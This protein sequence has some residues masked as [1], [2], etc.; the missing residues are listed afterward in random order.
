MYRG[1]TGVEDS[2][3]WTTEFYI[4]GDGNS[5]TGY[6]G[7]SLYANT[8]SST[9]VYRVLTET[10]PGELSNVKTSE[11]EHGSL[12]L[13]GMEVFSQ[14]STDLISMQLSPT[15]VTFGAK[16]S[17]PKSEDKVIVVT[18]E[19]SLTA[20][21]SGTLSWNYKSQNIPSWF[22]VS[23][24]GSQ[25]V[26]KL[27]EENASGQRT[28][29]LPVVGSYT[30]PDGRGG[31]VIQYITVVQESAAEEVKPEI[32]VSV[33]PDNLFFDAEPS[34]S[35]YVLV[36]I[37]DG[38]DYKYGIRYDGD[39]EVGWINV[40]KNGDK[41]TVWCL[42]NKDA[43]ARRGYIDI[44]PLEGDGTVKATITI[45]Q[46]GA[47]YPADTKLEFSVTPTTLKT[48]FY[49]AAL[50]AY[51]KVTPGATVEIVGAD[52]E[53]PEWILVAD[54]PEV[55]DSGE[56]GDYINIE[57]EMN[58]G[59]AAREVDIIVKATLPSL[60]PNNPPQVATERIHI[61]QKGNNDDEL[62]PDE[63]TAEEM[64]MS[65][66]A[67]QDEMLN[68]LDP[69]RHTEAY[70]KE[71]SDNIA[72]WEPW[73]DADWLTVG[74]DTDA[75][76]AFIYADAEQNTSAQTR[77]AAVYVTAYNRD[78]T[79]SKVFFVGYV[80]QDFCPS[81]TIDEVHGYLF[82]AIPQGPKDI[83]CV[84][85]GAAKVQQSGMF[86]SAS[87][88]EGNKLRVYMD[89]NTGNAR[90]LQILVTASNSTGETATGSVVVNQKSGSSY[91]GGSGGDSGSSG[92]GGD[93][94]GGDSGGGDSGGGDSG[95]G[96]AVEEIG[97]FYVTKAIDITAPDF[98][99]NNIKYENSNSTTPWHKNG[100][101][102]IITRYIVLFSCMRIFE[103]RYVVLVPTY[104][105]RTQAAM[106]NI[107]NLVRQRKAPSRT[108]VAA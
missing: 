38:G 13:G 67:W 16:F 45:N 66:N 32:L 55:G 6:A 85:V 57:L 54:I 53:W 83:N 26:I 10:A 87:L 68:A 64:S 62:I 30:L 96:G 108:V 28:A 21:P 60:N 34:N 8:G 93:S 92:G 9:L 33:Q 43:N 24:S 105:E 71:E 27:A 107:I 90:G 56:L 72:D 35:Q 78:R 12:N 52:G 41:L 15:R 59:A 86:G 97:N 44:I 47:D 50:E 61:Y 19:K 102:D 36:S 25:L 29:L 40:A 100:V 5:R 103:D 84:V 89:A 94:G 63:P 22:N 4:D 99:E 88:I 20:E 69:I 17:D 23:A 91:S 77:K 31:E 1:L 106:D 37:G 42:N 73:T 7:S 3:Y 75:G 2:Q 104:Q 46:A 51:Y 82:D 18:L 11:I 14:M 81:V 70:I 79:K 74:R 49:A 98:D 76:H 48:N 58:E 39:G 80:T 101:W 65:F 95:D